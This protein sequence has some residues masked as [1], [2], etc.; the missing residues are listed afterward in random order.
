MA[1]SVTLD[2]VLRRVSEDGLQLSV[3]GAPW[4]SCRAV[5][6]AA[7]SQ[8]GL[9]LEFAGEADQED[10][11]VVL[12]AVRQNGLALEFAAD[13]LKLTDEE[14]NWAALEACPLALGDVS[15]WF[16]ARRDWTLSAVSRDPR[17]LALSDWGYHDDEEMCLIAARQCGH[18]LQWCDSKQ[19]SV[20]WAAVRQNGYA[21][22]WLEG[23]TKLTDDDDLC[24]LAVSGDGMALEFCSRRARHTRS[25]VEAAV[26]KD[27]LALLFW[28]DVGERYCRE[29]V[30]Q[31]V[32][33]NWRICTYLRGALD[34][35]EIREAILHQWPLWKLAGV[36]A[37]SA[38]SSV[39]FGAW[40]PGWTPEEA[41]RIW[42]ERPS[43]ARLEAG[44]N[45]SLPRVPVRESGAICSE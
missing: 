12:A 42:L 31:A 5:V 26:H 10:R 13:P 29:L 33:S 30:F 25:I 24:R 3:F 34:K 32:V 11:E 7:V 28:E 19:R 36:S 45:S 38:G 6:L 44:D 39:E 27:G 4:N 21:M 41:S 1:A 2:E 37:G 18:A 9:A 20:V 23:L 22:S 15:L 40:P 43:G 17:A 16:F 8:N 14:I 35:T